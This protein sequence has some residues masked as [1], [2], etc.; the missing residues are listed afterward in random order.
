M[1]ADNDH[2]EFPGN[3]N[4]GPAIEERSGVEEKE[5]KN[6]TRKILI[7]QEPTRKYANNNTTTEKIKTTRSRTRNHGEAYFD[8]WHFDSVASFSKLPAPKIRG[9]FVENFDM[10][11]ENVSA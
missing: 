10:A 1:Y 2:H 5:K 3:R 6:T 9:A 8:V 7:K 11:C 4:V